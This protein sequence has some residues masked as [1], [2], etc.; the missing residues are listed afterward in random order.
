MLSRHK[1]PASR[2]ES[3][4]EHQQELK[5]EEEDSNRLRGEAE[6]TGEWEVEEELREI[7]ITT[8]HPG[9]ILWR[10]CLVQR[11]SVSTSRTKGKEEN[12]RSLGTDT[13]RVERSRKV[14]SPWGSFGSQAVTCRGECA[15]REGYRTRSFLSLPR[16]A[17]LSVGLLY[18][19]LT[20]GE[21]CEF[22]H[23]C[24]GQEEPLLWNL[25]FDTPQINLRIRGMCLSGQAYGRH[26]SV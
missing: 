22:T 21:V 23:S 8:I 7:I 11:E 10:E 9:R 1:A 17:C 3:L 20:E 4:E 2:A 12:L 25:F 5:E 19:L 13:G 14:F 6:G 18:V 26:L 15:R 24:H 16:P